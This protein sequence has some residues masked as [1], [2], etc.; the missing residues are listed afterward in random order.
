MENKGKI[1]SSRFLAQVGIQVQTAGRDES[2][3]VSWQ[4][5]LVHETRPQ[6]D[7]N[8]FPYHYQQQ[9]STRSGRV[10]NYGRRAE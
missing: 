4:A 2:E 8:R 1:H 5:N 10:L 7:E 6:S 3:C 9:Q